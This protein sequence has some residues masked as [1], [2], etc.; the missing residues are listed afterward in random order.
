[1]SVQYAIDNVLSYNPVALW[2]VQEAAGMPQDVSGNGNHMTGLSA[3]LDAQEGP[4][5]VDDTSMVCDPNEGASR[6]QVMAVTDNLALAGWFFPDSVTGTN[7]ALIANY[8]VFNGY[9]IVLSDNL[10]IRGVLNNVELMAESTGT[11]I[12]DAWNFVAMEREAG[13]WKYYINGDLDNG[14]VSGSTPATPS[15]A[16]AVIGTNGATMTMAAA[17]CAMYDS[18]VGAD[19]WADQ[20]EVFTSAPF[21]PGH[22]RI[23]GPLQLAAAAADLFVV[24]TGQRCQLR[25]VTLSN[26]TGSL[27]KVTFSIGTDAAGTRWF[28]Q[29]DVPAGE[30]RDI[31][32]M[33]A[34]TLEA[35]EK[36]QGYADAASAVVVTIDGYVTQT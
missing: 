21:S 9:M 22:Q 34:H 2:P 3:A 33:I 11:L 7:N 27:R 20:Y 25:N 4:L 30:S 15:A 6:A 31:R 32:R 19:G 5:V 23:V 28:D 26:P 35:G 14:S 24:P 36:L 10:K 12:A 13:T 16:T 17:W 29:Y 18:V 8:Q 1:M